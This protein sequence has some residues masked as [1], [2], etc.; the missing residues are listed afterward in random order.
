M[1]R[2]KQDS[3]YSL[4]H[5]E[6]IDGK[7]YVRLMYFDEKAGRRRSKAR[8]IHSVDDYA[9]ALEYLKK[10]IGEQPP[11]HDP[12]K[13]TFEELMAEFKKAKPKT[14]EWYL[15]PIEEHFGKRKL[16]SI[17]YG[18][19]K[20][21][22]ALRQAVPHKVTGEPR[23]HSTINRELEALREVLLYAVRHDW[24][25]KNPFGKGPALILKS[26][27]EA[28]NRIPSPEEEAAILE[29]CANLNDW[30]ARKC[31]A[32]GITR[33]QFAKLIGAEAMARIE[34]DKGIK[35]SDIALAAEILGESFA[36]TQE[37][38]RGKR[39]HLRAILIA[40][41]HTGLRK[42]ALLS[43]TW[44]NVDLQEGYMQIPKGPRNKK[45]PPLIWM[46]NRLR[47]EFLKL[48]EKSDKNPKSQIFGGIKDFKKAYGHVCE[49]AGVEDLHIHDW[50]HGYV[51][52]MAEADV[53]E[54]IAMR[55]AGHTNPE[56]HWIY[57]NIDKR[58]AK[59]IA[60]KLNKLHDERERRSGEEVADATGMVN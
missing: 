44:S 16:K 55:A 25:A 59:G 18:D 2:S 57:T 38:A 51:T 9:A 32:K 13:I 46:T 26:E 19:L 53:E 5:V 20:E 24:L 30:A 23:K 58:L 7:P 36:D 33:E 54:R 45:R 28:R 40:L 43:L 21:F 49:L 29:W 17:T 50:K 56:T 22:K 10:E 6:P 15:T 47:D 34:A 39:G 41:R 8:R 27:E 3:V 52:D 14:P 35:D 31:E 37:I 48:W 1:A 12:E 60:D 4:P 42:G 11:D